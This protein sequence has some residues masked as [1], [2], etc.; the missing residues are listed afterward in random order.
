MVFFILVNPNGKPI[1]SYK[2]SFNSLLD[3]VNLSFDDEGKRRSPYSL[4]HTYITMRLMEGVNVYELSSNVGT[5]VEMI[6]NYYGHLLNRD[7]K[8]VSEVTKNTFTKDHQTSS[9]DFLNS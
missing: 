3:K 9:I 2:G 6:E 5:S 7:P 4:R 1:Q 8:V